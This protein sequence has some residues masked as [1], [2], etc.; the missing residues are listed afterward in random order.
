MKAAED[1]L[2]TAIVSYLKMEYE[3]FILCI[4]RRSISKVSFAK[5]QSQEDRIR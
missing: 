5:A 1:K 3:C 2:Q 4:F